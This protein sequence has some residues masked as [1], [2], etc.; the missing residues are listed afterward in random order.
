[1]REDD[2]IAQRQQRQFDG[3]RERVGVRHYD[4]FEIGMCPLR[5]GGEPQFKTRLSWSR[6]PLADRRI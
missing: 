2:D 5:G 4:A 3:F 6:K 1:V